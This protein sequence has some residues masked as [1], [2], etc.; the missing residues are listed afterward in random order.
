MLAVLELT[1]RRIDGTSF[2]SPEDF[3]EYCR[4]MLRQQYL[5]RFWDSQLKEQRW[6]IK[7]G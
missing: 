4:A 1:G 6:R 3:I 7:K 2:D 5:R